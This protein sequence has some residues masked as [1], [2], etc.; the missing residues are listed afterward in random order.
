MGYRY[1]DA[2][3][4]SPAWPFG[5]GLS[6]STFEYSA[7]AVAGALTTDPASSVN[8]SFTVALAPGSPA[9]AE[10]AQLYLQWA[11]GLGEP[12]QSL[13]GFAKVQLT[14]A[15]PSATVTIPLRGA[16][17]A[18]WD[19][20]SDDWMIHAGAYGVAVG[21]GSRDRRLEAQLTVESITH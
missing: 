16:D 19:E 21:G 12:P 9:G 11:P 6:Y 8:I 10:V 20:A 5:H 17:V 7:L 14:P 13:K 15:A 4:T 18:V 2:M 1:Y 3:G